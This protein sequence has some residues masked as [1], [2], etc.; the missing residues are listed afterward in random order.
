MVT[1]PYDD[2]DDQPTLQR[3]PA[4]AFA[5]NDSGVRAAFGVPLRPLDEALDH[6]FVEE[7][8]AVDRAPLGAA[9]DDQTVAVAMAGVLGDV[10]PADL[11][12]PTPSLPLDVA[13]LLLRASAPSEPPPGPGDDDE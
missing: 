13:S 8:T 1:D 4:G 3:P 12:G 2:D 5:K 6:G 10:L 7:K 9:N 11:E